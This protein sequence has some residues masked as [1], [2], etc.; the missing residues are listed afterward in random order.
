MTDAHKN[1]DRF[2]GFAG[3]YNGVRP[4]C[5]E[6]VTEI[7]TRY[8]G[9]HPRT[10]VDLG[11]GTGLSSLVWRGRADKIIGIEPSG[12]MLAQAVASTEGLPEIEFIRAFSDNTGLES[13]IADIVTCSQSFHWMEPFSTLREVDRI[14]RP[15]GVFAAYDCD[16]PVVSVADV[17]R[18]EEKLF[19]KINDIQFNDGEYKD[20]FI[21]YPKTRHLENIRQSGFFSYAREI[22]F[23]KTE[24]CGADRRYGL[25]L[26]QGAIQSILKKNPSLIE[27]DLA[28]FRAVVD[29][30]FG[31][32]TLQIEFCYRMRLGMKGE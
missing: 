29:G 1:A 14:L 23:S 11:C 21:Q 15:G 16:W 26:S 27:D 30:F 3:L 25:V 8:L 18:A 7:L 19:E 10:V 4:A 17:D 20:A 31:D 13:G 5:P 32:R 28:G 6:Y 22:V 12:D 24:D 2:G 9:R